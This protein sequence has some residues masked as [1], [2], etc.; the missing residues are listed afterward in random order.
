MSE[1]QKKSYGYSDEVM[2]RY[3]SDEFV[4]TLDKS[5]EFVG[6]G[7]VGAPACGDVLRL[8]IECDEKRQ[9]IIKVRFK[10]FGCNA[11]IASS[12]YAAEKLEGLTLDESAKI[13]NDDIFQK[14]ALPPIKR[15]CSLLAEE[16]IAAALKDLK[17]KINT[18]E[19]EE[20]EEE[21][22]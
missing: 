6:T 18:E 11:A 19:D 14:L 4:G 3:R 7:L 10:A 16:A 12:A 2:D 21:E 9:K 15:H 1:G 22:V 8:Q 13:T 20:K 17:N 5:S